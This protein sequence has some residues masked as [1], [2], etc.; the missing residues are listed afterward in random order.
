MIDIIQRPVAFARPVK[1]N[2]NRQLPN[3]LAQRHPIVP[4]Q[5]P[6][7]EVAETPVMTPPNAAPA[8]INCMK[9]DPI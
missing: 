5:P 7:N 6:Q 9:E 1:S 8:K 2:S 4:S 3:A